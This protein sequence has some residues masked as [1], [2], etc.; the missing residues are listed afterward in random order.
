MP[1]PDCQ[2][3]PW[4][5][6]VVD[7]NRPEEVA[8]ARALA[9]VRGCCSP[10]SPAPT[11][12]GLGR[13]SRRC[14]GGAS[15]NGDIGGGR[16]LSQRVER[17]QPKCTSR[18]APPPPGIGAFTACWPGW[19]PAPG[20][21]ERA[22]PRQEV[23]GLIDAVRRLQRL[24]GVRLLIDYVPIYKDGGTETTH[25]VRSGTLYKSMTCVNW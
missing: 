17:W 1:R 16:E 6:V 14:C 25:S 15:L 23:R 9:A 8:A 12:H 2:P 21:A 19:W 22:P 18:P 3:Q 7:P 20:G 5:A 4:R 24:P 10:S 13:P 11:R